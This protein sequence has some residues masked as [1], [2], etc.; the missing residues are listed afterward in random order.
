MTARPYHPAAPLPKGL[1]L[2]PIT[3]DF[4]AQQEEQIPP[5]E[6]VALDD[7]GDYA[8]C[9]VDM[10]TPGDTF[11]RAY[12]LKHRLESD[13]ACNG[14]LSAHRLLCLAAQNGFPI[15]SDKK[16]GVHYIGVD[17]ECWRSVNAGEVCAPAGAAFDLM[18][19]AFPPRQKRKPHRRR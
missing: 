8:A 5:G 18:R 13:A 11:F 3:P 12:W 15:A 6:R 4:F 19:A 14:Y 10:L 2:V 16:T 9:A 7:G 1:T 17:A